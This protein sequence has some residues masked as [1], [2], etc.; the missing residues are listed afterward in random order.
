[1]STPAAPAAAHA[2]VP[3]HTHGHAHDHSDGQA[4]GPTQVNPQ[5]RARAHGPHA[6]AQPPAAG[7]GATLLMAGAASRVGGALG[8]LLLL[9]AAV[10]WALGEPA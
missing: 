9:W 10:A 3:G 4:H 8:L 7:L 5:A 6:P 2:E 1:M